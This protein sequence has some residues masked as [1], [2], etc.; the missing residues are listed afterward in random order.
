MEAILEAKEKLEQAVRLDAYFDTIIQENAQV[1]REVQDM[2]RKSPTLDEVLTASGYT[3]EVEER[4]RVRS[5]EQGIEQ[6]IER[7]IEQAGERFVCNLLK[8]GLSVEK[9]A[10]IAELPVE[11]VRALSVR[12]ADFAHIKE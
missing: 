5:M 3:Y 1:L 2:R 6:G 4:G 10:A 11:K 9:I 12:T 7:G 8:E